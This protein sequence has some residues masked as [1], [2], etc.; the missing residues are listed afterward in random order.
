MSV[1]KC[2]AA[3]DAMIFRQLP[4][5][6]AGFEALRAFLAQGELRF[7]N[8]ETTVH[9]FETY[10]A[11]LSGGSWF[12][13]APRVLDSVKAFGFNTLTTAN[14]HAMDYS[15]AGLLKTLA[16][17][18]AAGLS[19]CGTGRSLAE[20]SAPVYLDAPGGRY[21]VIG[22]C[23]T[24]YPDAAAGE[25]TRTMPGRPGLNGLRFDTRYELPEAQ[26][27][28]LRG[29]AAM[30]E[31]NADREL[32]R[33]QGY[34]PALPEGTAEFGALCF[35][36]AEKPGVRTRVNAVDMARTEKMIRE[37]RF[38]ADYVLVSIHAHECAGAAKHLPAEFCVE[39]AHRCIDAGAHAVVGTG[40]HL[41][42]PIEI[43]KG[44]PIF[45]SL[46][47]FIIQLETVEKAPAGFFEKQGMT[48]NEGLDELFEKRSD[49][50][51]KGLYYSRVMF[52]AVVPYWETEDGKLRALKLMPVELGFGK[53]RSVGGWPAPDTHSGILERLAEMSLPYGTKIEIGSDGIGSVV[54]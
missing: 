14:N 30:L 22:A 29:I 51:K 43:Y 13:A 31:L 34:L 9:N 41:L 53:K 44:C 6:Y 54:L 38:M 17:L 42:R 46:G 4:G 7:L 15:H 19:V 28:Q 5:Q 24:F 39:F 47:D 23:S 20:A 36:R 2:T 16:Y 18:Q 32:E 1:M 12:C 52:E 3:G 26:L 49:H 21:A 33:A 48:G 35:S 50:G 10:G 27:A 45:Y 40:P 37:A 25:Q 8:L 11:A